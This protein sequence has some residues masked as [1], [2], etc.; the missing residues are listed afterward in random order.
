MPLYEFVCQDCGT[1]FEKVVSF[2]ATSTLV[3]TACDST[4]VKRKMSAPA[5]HFKGSG[6]YITDSKKS[7]S[8]TSVAST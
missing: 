3:C 7:S 4:E 1:N 6:W 8:T 5:I 2:T